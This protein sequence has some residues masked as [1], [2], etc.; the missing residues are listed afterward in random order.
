MVENR[1]R[2][3]GQH[4]CSVSAYE[5]D[6]AVDCGGDACVVLDKGHAAVRKTHAAAD[7]LSAFIDGYLLMR[8]SEYRKGMVRYD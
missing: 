8:R 5:F 2:Y 1:F 7:T 4:D 3:L 6:A